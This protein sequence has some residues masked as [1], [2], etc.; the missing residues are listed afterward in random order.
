MKVL[1]RQY[2]RNQDRDQGF[3]LIELVITIAII[4]IIAA[5]AAPSMQK[6]IQ[7]AKTNDA[8]N[9]IEA[10]LKDAKSQALITQKNIKVVL[11]DTSTNKNLKLFYV[12]DDTTKTVPLATYTLDKNISIITDASN[13]TAVSFTPYK[14][15]YP[16]DTGTRPDNTDTDSST[17]FSVCYGAG[18]DKYTIMVD[19]SSNIVTSKM[20]RVHEFTKRHWL[21]RSAGSIDVVSN[22]GAWIHCDADDRS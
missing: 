6:Q 19:A 14:N 20:G 22:R 16:G 5:M 15:A 1:N 21:N 7:Q 13:L 10:A 4:A 17:N 8:A 9:I 18:S 2:H 12:G 11:T 3:T